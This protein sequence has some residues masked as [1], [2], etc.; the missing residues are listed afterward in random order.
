MHDGDELVRTAIFVGGGSHSG[1]RSFGM[2]HIG[3]LSGLE[4]AQRFRDYLQ[5][6][7]IPAVLEQRDTGWLVWIRNE[8]QVARARGEL[9]LF[10]ERPDDPRFVEPAARVRD[11]RQQATRRVV[12]A[13]RPIRRP[14]LAQIFR[15]AP[16]TVAV[17]WLTIFVTLA[18]SMGS[19][20]TSKT[21]QSL[22]FQN[23]VHAPG[24]NLRLLGA[25]STSSEVSGGGWRPQSFYTLDG[26]TGC[27]VCC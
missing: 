21:L 18:S 4:P 10:E 19:D 25:P 15:R 20:C 7:Q 13:A 5:A 3:T 12:D 22:A 17:L 11:E 6:L 27:S 9:A 24:D 16:L 1:Q 14:T 8:D 26:F 2:R 23:P